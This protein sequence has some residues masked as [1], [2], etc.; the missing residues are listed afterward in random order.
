MR[1]IHRVLVLAMC[2]FAIGLW[3]QTPSTKTSGQFKTEPMPVPMNRQV[4]VDD[5]LH[6]LSEQLNLTKAQQTKV[7]PILERYL[8]QRQ[9]IELN[10]KLSPDVKSARLQ[11]SERSSNTKIRALLTPVQ[12]KTFDDI[13]GTDD[14][15]AQRPSKAQKKK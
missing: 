2:T 7:K 4:N 8:R 10:N 9:Q 11:S 3:A 12:K 6:M 1:L 15:T 5:H 14:E 13:M